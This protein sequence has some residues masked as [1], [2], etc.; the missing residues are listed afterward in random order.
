MGAREGMSP[1]LFCRN[2]LCRRA[3]WIALS[4]ALP[5]FPTSSAGQDSAPASAPEKPAPSA[6]QEAAPKPKTDA[7]SEISQVDSAATFKVRVNLVQVRVIV[8][9]SSGKPIDNLTRQDFLL[10]DQSKLQNISN[11]SV[12]TTQTRLQRAATIAKDAGGRIRRRRHGRTQAARSAGAIRS[13]GF[14]DTHLSL[15]DA[16]FARSQSGRFLELHCSYRSRRDPIPPRVRVRWSSLLTGQRCTG[17]SWNCAASPNAPI[18]WFGLSRCNALHRRPDR[19]QAR[20]P[21]G[22][23]GGGRNNPVPVWRDESKRAQAV[24]IVESAALRALNAGT[25]KMSS[26]T[27]IWKTA[28]RR[29]ANMPGERIMLRSPGLSAY[30]RFLDE[31][32][33]IDRANRSNVVN[34]HARRA[35]TLHPRRMGDHHADHPRQLSHRGG[36]EPC[37]A[38]RHVGQSAQRVF[39]M[40]VGELISTSPAFQRPKRRDSTIGTACA[41]LLSSPPN[42]HWIVFFHRHGNRLGIVLVFR[43][44]LRC[45][46]LHRD[47]PN[48][49]IGALGRGTIPRSPGATL[50]GQ[51]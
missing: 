18:D 2:P 45:S 32:G 21:G 16:T 35:W 51:Q 46:A 10:Y 29:L 28:L 9:D 49:S 27:G 14:D 6:P 13:S 8:R 3:L 5:F 7:S 26:P 34:Q 38:H 19:K 22:C 11:F 43:S 41:R 37:T 30:H 25:L 15:Q 40:P 4:I 39:Q 42:W 23:R 33:V 1:R 12:E 50:P 31:S 20:Y 17:R 48:Q 44:G 47:N 36:E 24:P